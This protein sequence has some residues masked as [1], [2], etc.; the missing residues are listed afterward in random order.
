MSKYWIDRIEK[1]WNSCIPN[2][3]LNKEPKLIHVD[4]GIYMCRLIWE[5]Y[6]ELKNALCEADK[7]IIEI[8][9][10]LA[11]MK[12]LIYGCVSRYGFQNVWE[13]S[14]FKW[15]TNIPEA[16][17]ELM[18]DIRAD[19]IENVLMG[20]KTIERLVNNLMF[21]YK[22]TDNND[23]IMES[24]HISNLTKVIDG[25]VIMM[26]DLKIKKPPTFI[27]PDLSFLAL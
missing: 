14:K 20:F 18:E 1:E 22:L 24:V 7:N 26:D 11:D 15:T 8:A 19:K 25:S 6:I 16:I 13:I 9:D 3:E 12:Y 23:R 21:T 27:E 2:I 4:Q 10:A 17:D 5:E